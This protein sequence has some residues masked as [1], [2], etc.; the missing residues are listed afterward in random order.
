MIIPEVVR[1]GSCDYSVEFTDRDLVA[2]G[3]ESLAVIEYNNH[4]IEISNKLGDIQTQELSFL[5]EMFHGILRDRAIEVEEEEF[6]VDELAKAMHQIIRDNP[7]M[8]LD[9]KDI[10]FEDE[11]E[12]E[13]N[14]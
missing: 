1:I 12:E 11:I 2:N 9:E 7:E 13:E 6:I 14:V 3:R 8:F 10:Y 5:H 4:K